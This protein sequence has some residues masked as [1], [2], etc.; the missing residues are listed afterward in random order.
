M[1]HIDADLNSKNTDHNLY[2]GYGAQTYTANTRIYASTG[3][4]DTTSAQYLLA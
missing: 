4:G 2:I 1:R 3:S